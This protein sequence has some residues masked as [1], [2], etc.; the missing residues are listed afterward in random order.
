LEQL[1]KA[2]MVALVEQVA[3]ASKPRAAGVE[4]VP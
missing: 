3:V 2:T 4:Q 1:V